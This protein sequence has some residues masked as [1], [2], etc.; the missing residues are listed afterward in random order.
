MKNIRTIGVI[1]E[2]GQLTIPEKVR[3]TLDWVSPSSIVTIST[4]T[5]KPNE[6]IIRPHEKERVIDWNTLWNNIYL[7]RS[8]KG[9]GENLAKFI[10]RDREQH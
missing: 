8:F 4:S 1:R 6:I 2:R 7:S 10:A 3:N 5:E 9:N